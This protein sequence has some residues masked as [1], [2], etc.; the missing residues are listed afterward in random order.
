MSTSSNLQDAIARMVVKHGEAF[1]TSVKDWGDSR[2]RSLYEPEEHMKT[3]S[4]KKM[5]GYTEDY[6][7]KVY[8]TMSSESNVGI[9]ALITC[10]CG[11]VTDVAFIV[12]DAGLA[13]ILKWIMESE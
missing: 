2:G 11:R 8:D 6:S 1:N 7:W 9:K 10:D 4:V 13:T 12:P 3:C 5:T